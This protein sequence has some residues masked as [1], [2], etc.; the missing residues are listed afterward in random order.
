MNPSKTD[1]FNIVTIF[2]PS[3]EP[4]QVWYDSE[5]FATI[6]AGRAVQLTKLIAGD[7]NHGNV[8]HLIDRMILKS[9]GAARKNDPDLRAAW[10]EKIVLGDQVNSSPVIPTEIDLAK[11]LQKELLAQPVNVPLPT[12]EPAPTP[13]ALPTPAEPEKRFDPYTGEPLAKKLTG[14][15]P[16]QVKTD[17]VEIVPVETGGL[18]ADAILN[19]PLP[20][21]DPETNTILEN[22]RSKGDGEEEARVLRVEDE[23]AD[24]PPAP[25][26]PKRTA[27]PNKE[28]L[29]EYAR[30]VLMM[31][32]NDEDTRKQ[33][34]SRSVEEL[35]SDLRY[36]VYA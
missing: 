19:K 20:H 3:S 16:D 26:Q 14:I 4:F 2:N 17:N 21:P 13:P 5:L 29:I 35:M 25:D 30:T 36:D 23:E 12:I 7:A 22:L 8:K 34:E 9:A 15:T 6:P 27:T 28:E 31:D 11:K 1:L 24:L 32:V 10:S 33:L 18:N